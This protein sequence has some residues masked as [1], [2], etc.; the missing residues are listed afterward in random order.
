MEAALSSRSQGHD[1]EMFAAL[2]G[3]YT[4]GNTEMQNKRRAWTSCC[5][6]R[7]A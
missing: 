2:L 4:A 5:R 7:C 3:M 6:T 1:E